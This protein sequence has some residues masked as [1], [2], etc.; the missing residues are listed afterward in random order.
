M[1]FL[2]GKLINLTL[3]G[4]L[5]GIKVFLNIKGH[6]FRDDPLM[7]DLRPDILKAYLQE[8][9]EL[10]EISGKFYISS[11]LEIVKLEICKG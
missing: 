11:N 6:Y 2:K 4:T 3:T 9:E 5:F 1:S 8:K 10:K 7:E